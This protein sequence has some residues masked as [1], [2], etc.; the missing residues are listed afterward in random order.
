MESWLSPASPDYLREVN[1]AVVDF[2]RGPRDNYQIGSS[3]M[4]APGDTQTN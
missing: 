2:A 4:G 3:P 1:V